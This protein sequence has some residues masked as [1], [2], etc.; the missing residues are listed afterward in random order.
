M[1]RLLLPLLALTAGLL[2]PITAKAESVWL[3]LMNGHYSATAFEKIQM[4]DMNECQ[5]QGASYVAHEGEEM[6]L[7]FT[8]RYKEFICIKG[9]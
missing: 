5:L 2:S 4:T 6:K 7:G 9:K 3:V 8:R 1:K